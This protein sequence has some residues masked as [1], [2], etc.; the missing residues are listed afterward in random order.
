M[1]NKLPRIEINKWV[2][3]DYESKN[4]YYINNA[5]ARYFS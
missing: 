1:T 4:R 5:L 3:Y 2:R